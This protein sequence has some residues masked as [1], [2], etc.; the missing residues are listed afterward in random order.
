[1]TA[2]QEP[3]TIGTVR[4]SPGDWVVGDEDGAVVVPSERGEEILAAAETKVGTENLVRQ[5]VREGMTPLE[6]YERY[7]AF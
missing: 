4:V 1:M 7:G 3:V 5:A 2:T 6:A